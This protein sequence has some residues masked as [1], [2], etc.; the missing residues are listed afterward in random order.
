MSALYLC[1]VPSKQI[2]HI[3]KWKQKTNLVVA[4]YSGIIKPSYGGLW[5]GAS[6]A[7]HGSYKCGKGWSDV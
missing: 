1:T 3:P 7:F 5:S 2:A 6:I 4:L